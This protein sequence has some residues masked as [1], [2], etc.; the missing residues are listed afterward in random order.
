MFVGRE[1]AIR[2]AVA[3]LERV[4][5]A[6]LC[7]RPGVGK[8]SL[9]YTIAGTWPHPVHHVAARPEVGVGPL[10]D[11]V[12]RRLAR[13]SI[14]QA[15]DDEERFADVAARLDEQQALLVIDDVHA[16]SAE[17]REE[18]VFGVARLL[19]RGRLIVTS[20][21]RLEA[22]P[23]AP[24]HLVV[25]VEDLTIDDARALWLTLDELHGEQPGFEEA[26]AR[27]GGNPFYLRR[28]HARRPEPSGQD[29]VTE[30][31]RGLGPEE[32]RVALAVALTDAALPA[33]LLAGVGAGGDDAIE[34]LAQRMVIEIDGAGLVSMHDVFRQALAAAG[35][36]EIAQVRATLVR[37]LPEAPLDVVVA[38]REVTRHLM[39]LERFADAGRHLLANAIELVR[40]GAASEL[41]ADLEAIPAAARATGIE[42]ARARLYTRTLQ[43]RRAADLL[44]GLTETRAAPPGD[45]AAA[46][47]NVSMLLG[48]LDAAERALAVVLGDPAVA[49]ATRVRALT[50]LAIVRMFAGRGA[51]ARAFLDEAASAAPEPAQRGI[52][53]VC[54][55]FTLLVEG[56]DPDQALDDVRRAFSCFR[57]DPSSFRG[58]RLLP[59]LHATLLARS[60]RIDDAGRL[61]VDLETR[62]SGTNDLRLRVLIGSVLT[63]L[64]FE[65]GDRRVA[66]AE[67]RAMAGSAERSE[68]VLFYIWVEG[69]RARA[70]LFSGRRAEGLTALERATA[71]ARTR[72]LVGLVRPLLRVEEEADP[73]LLPRGGALPRSR[74]V[75]ASVLAALDAARRG[76]RDEAA[77]H[78]AAAEDA[79]PRTS[80]GDWRIDYALDAAIAR[81]ARAAL[82]SGDD[83]RREI[84][85]A[86][87][88]AVDGGVDASVAATLPRLLGSLRLHTAVGWRLAHEPP[89][90]LGDY[91]VVVDAR[92]HELRSGA[93]T[94]AFSRRPAV[95]QILYALLRRRGTAVTKEELSRTLWTGEYHPLVHDNP[96]KVNVRNLRRELD[97]TGLVVEHSGEGYRL[98][99]ATRLL[100][101][102]LV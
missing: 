30:L 61:F 2:R 18:T 86:V 69:L 46:L 64:R 40:H 49:P 62:L 95:R 53:L 34:R 92:S 19:T 36:D 85:A 96:L 82:Q 39:A 89:D 52:F 54:R 11:D 23:P 42:L 72:G 24:D 37:V 32:R 51:E 6:V 41:L 9:A 66:L 63:L 56:I 70:L 59:Y 99:T 98:K 91:Q 102:D 15:A 45:V 21:E 4:P 22:G 31:L 88:G 84:E 90:D 76:D 83:R 17:R 43:L 48:D 10:L 60:G 5:L 74:A 7:G 16:L 44:A 25:Q 100:F 75:R 79:A 26:W 78:L 58:S 8:S 13:G 38:V 73:F 68:D 33:S 55:A 87:R 97:G 14:H 29:P 27:F 101:I 57:D 93:R 71:R 94:I 3:G 67:Y 47:G 77:A 35:P 1:D 81:V 12:R 28:A 20:R 80:E 65:R 50:T